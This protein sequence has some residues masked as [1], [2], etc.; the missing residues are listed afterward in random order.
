MRTQELVKQIHADIDAAQGLLVEEAT[1]RLSTYTETYD[2]KYIGEM[3][4]YGFHNAEIV[5]E[6]NKRK[7]EKEN[8]ERLLKLVEYYREKYPFQKFLTMPQLDAI[9]EKYNLIHAPVRN[10]LKTVPKKNLDEIAKAKEL[11]RHDEIKDSRFRGLFIAAPKS[12][13]DLQGLE[14]HG[15][16]GWLR[17]EPKDPIVFRYVNGGIQVLTKWGPE[18][19]DPMLTNP[20]DN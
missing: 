20:I 8:T 2:E 14:K 12:H 16:R 18:A 19:E 9:C 10:Y 1:K 15:K 4:K 17:P 13:F 5:Q 6:Y 3:E 11:E 7:R